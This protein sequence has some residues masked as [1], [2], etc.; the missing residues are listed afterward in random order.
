M[1]HINILTEKAEMRKTI[2]LHK[3][4]SN[5]HSNDDK[6]TEGIIK[7]QLIMLVIM[8]MVLMMMM[9]IMMAMMIMMAMIM[10]MIIMIIIIT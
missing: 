9:I 7:M 1:T 8:M 5:K 3:E 2:A 4:G 6:V 10:M